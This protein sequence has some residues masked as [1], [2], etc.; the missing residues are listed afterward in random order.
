M[1]LAFCLTMQAHSG[2][3]YENVVVQVSGYQEH[4]QRLR[5]KNSKNAVFWDV[6]SRE[7]NIN[8][9]FGGTCFPR[10]QGLRNNASDEKC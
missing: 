4:A 7:Y 8:R 6:V 3:S 1:R 2:S 5:I 9:R 10:L